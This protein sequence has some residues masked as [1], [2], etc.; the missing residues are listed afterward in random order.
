MKQVI[1][2]ITLATGLLGGCGAPDGALDESVAEVSAPLTNGP[3]TLKNMQTGLCLGVKGGDPTYLT[4]F[5]VWTCD[6]SANQTFT[7]GPPSSS[8][9]AFISLPNGV[10]DNRCL[11]VSGPRNGDHTYVRHC[12][13]N[14]KPNYWR[15]IYSGN[16]SSGHECY[17]FENENAP[18]KVFGVKGGSTALGTPVILW[19]DFND[20]WSHRDQFWCVY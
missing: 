20:P 13:T 6:G 7:K 17:R 10:G 15:P 16:D 3:F 11:G 19:S 14:Y 5:I 2:S 12:I 8:N 4:P 9:P 1:G 18:G